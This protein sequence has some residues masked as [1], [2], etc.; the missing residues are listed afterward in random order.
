MGTSGRSHSGYFPGLQFLLEQLLL[1][2]LVPVRS[3]DL[4]RV[5]V[6]VGSSI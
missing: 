4:E 6:F 3:I 2:L 1:P 5:I